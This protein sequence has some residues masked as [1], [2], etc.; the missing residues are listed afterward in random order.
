MGSA[1]LLILTFFYGDTKERPAEFD[2]RVESAMVPIPQQ[3][4]LPTL[5]GECNVGEQFTFVL[6]CSV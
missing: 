1:V 6:L 3:R 4:V 5:P 2:Y